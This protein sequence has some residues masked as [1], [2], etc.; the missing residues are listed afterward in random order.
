MDYNLSTTWTVSLILLAFWELTWKGFALWKAARND[1]SGWF[2]ALLIVNSLGILPIIY[3]LTH[4]G[5]P[6]VNEEEI[7][8]EKAIPVHG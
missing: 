3:L 6:E 8:H 4:R 1:Q 5:T 2:V 7:S